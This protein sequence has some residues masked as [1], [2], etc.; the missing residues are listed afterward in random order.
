MIRMLLCFLLAAFSIGTSSAQLGYMNRKAFKVFKSS[1]LLFVRSGNEKIDVEVENFLKNEWNYIPYKVINYEEHQS[2]IGNPEYSF[3]T[4][5]NLSFYAESEG[6]KMT[7]LWVRVTNKKDGKTGEL[8][9]GNLVGIIVFD[10][11]RDPEDGGSTY[12]YKL[13]DLL[14]SLQ[15]MYVYS[16]GN[17]YLTSE[18]TKKYY[19]NNRGKLVNHTL[20]IESALLDEEF[21]NDLNE[22]SKY[23]PAPYK[24]VSGQEVAEAI[25]SRDSQYA[26][27]YVWRDG[28]AVE[29]F[30][31][32]AGTGEVL[33]HT[34]SFE[35]KNE[36][37]KIHPKFF[38]QIKLEEYIK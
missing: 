26:Y 9:H 21:R 18:V 7:G 11:D 25:D 1:T 31:I 22:I 17:G 15:N 19:K 14:R 36:L 27:L 24:V 23:Y 35:Y 12:T 8:E 20:L 3:M 34:T 10:D 33:W 4:I 13:P 28:D 2:Y 30:I 6:I 32:E 16:E 38:K 29:Y 5:M 37:E